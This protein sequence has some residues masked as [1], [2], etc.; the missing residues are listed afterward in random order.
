MVQKK[1]KGFS[2][3][4]QSASGSQHDQDTGSGEYENTSGI[5]D[6]SIDERTIPGE[7]D[8]YEDSLEEEDLGD[9]DWDSVKEDQGARG[10]E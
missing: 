3:R 2:G 6:E 4:D 1:A 7:V 5:R 9:I 8:L 10:S